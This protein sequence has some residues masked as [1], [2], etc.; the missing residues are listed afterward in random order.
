[1]CSPFPEELCA[2]LKRNP[3]FVALCGKQ[4]GVLAEV[5]WGTKIAVFAPGLCHFLAEKPQFPGL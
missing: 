5:G 4:S 3:V 1:M 2:I